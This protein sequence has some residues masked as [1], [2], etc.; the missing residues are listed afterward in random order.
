LDD[1]AP[2][3]IR[4]NARALAIRGQGLLHQRAAVRQCPH[5]VFADGGASEFD[6]FREQ[7]RL[8]V[9]HDRA[10]EG[11]HVAVSKWF[12]SAPGTTLLEQEQRVIAARLGDCFGYHLLQIGSLANADFL[13]ASR[14]LHRFI[15]QLHPGGPRP[16]YPWLRAAATCLPIESDS[17]DVAV[18]PHVLEFESQAPQALREAAR[19]LV[20][21]GHLVVCG[22]NPWSLF[23]LWRLARRHSGNAPWSGRF[24][25]QSRLRDWFELLGLEMI[26][27]D[28]LFFRPPLRSERGL[29]KMNFLE[30]IGHSVCSPLCGA[31]V[32]TAR[33]RVTRATALRPRLQVR[34]KAVGVSLASPPARMRDE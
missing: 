30:Q 31:F 12:A 14:I 20:P 9:A 25:A 10:A 32:L 6:V 24:L 11:R 5:R 34:R 2:A 1:A 17:I 16:R 19:V 27:S 23:G 22:F 13:S 28:A 33:K 8:N 18:L 3:L 21:E 4:Q 26:S 7:N 29:Q 15:V